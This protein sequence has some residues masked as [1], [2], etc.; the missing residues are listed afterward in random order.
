M[1]VTPTP[2]DPHATRQ[3]SPPADPFLRIAMG[4]HRDPWQADYAAGAAAGV[5]AHVV[6]GGSAAVDAQGVARTVRDA[7]PFAL[8]VRWHR[9][10]GVAALAEF[11]RRDQV[12]ECVSGRHLHSAWTVVYSL[13]LAADCNPT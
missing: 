11:L 4:L 3:Q 12:V 1:R 7:G 9:R 8:G 13:H 10:A 6:G 2:D 5:V